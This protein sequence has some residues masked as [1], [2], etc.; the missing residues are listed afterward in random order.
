MNRAYKIIVALVVIIVVAY[1]GWHF[2][3]ARK[4]R[5]AGILSENV[6][7]TWNDWISD[8]TASIP[9]PQSDV[10]AAVR[11]IEKS[12]SDQLRDLKVVSQTDN[13][14]TVDFQLQGPGGQ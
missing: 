10:Y 11:D 7:H 1:G 3:Q 8:Y 2:Y 9:A 12:H 5:K 14:K 13:A 6:A 4:A